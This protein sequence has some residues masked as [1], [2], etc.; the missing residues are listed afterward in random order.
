M[1][2]N[3]ALI[4]GSYL[5][6][7]VP[8]LV[9]L[10]RLRGVVLEGD[11]HSSLWQRG[12]RLVG[13]IGLLGEFAK[14][15]IPILAGRALGFDLPIIV[16]AGLAAVAGQM[17]PVFLRFDGEKGNSIGLAM[18]GALAPVAL[19][20]SLIPIIVGA[21]VRTLPRLMDASQSL[22]TRLKFGGPPSRSLPLG[23]AIGFLALPIVS[24]GLGEPRAINSGCWALFVMIMVRRLTAGL[25]RDVKADAEVK[26]LVIN[27]LLYDRGLETDD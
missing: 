23:M 19:F 26:G 15:V 25:R 24:H 16:L 7:A 3:A 14:G 22:D 10:G 12:G 18:A 4:V 8:H 6:G 1:W 13:V 21:A 20:I 2:A 9:A 17:W 11:L 27:R 5:V